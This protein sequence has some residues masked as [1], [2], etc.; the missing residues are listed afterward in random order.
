MK[1][2]NIDEL[3]NRLDALFEKLELDNEIKEEVFAEIE[4]MPYLDCIKTKSGNLKGE[5]H[6]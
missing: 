2:I 6:K 5:W 1:L 4:D 3:E